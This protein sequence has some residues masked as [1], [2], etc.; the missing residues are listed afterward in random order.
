MP[1]F[2]TKALFP[3]KAHAMSESAH[4]ST[5]EAQHSPEELLDDVVLLEELR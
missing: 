2:K 1:I 4:Y 3:L 5:G